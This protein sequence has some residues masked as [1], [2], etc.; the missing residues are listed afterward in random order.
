MSYGPTQQSL[1][2]LQSHIYLLLFEH[3][4]VQSVNGIDI[5]FSTEHT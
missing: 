3:I 2:Y 4:Y 5:Y 1:K